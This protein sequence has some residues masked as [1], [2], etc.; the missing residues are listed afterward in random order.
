[1]ILAARINFQAMFKTFFKQLPKDRDGKVTVGGFEE[2]LKERNYQ[3]FSSG[4]LTELGKERNET[5]EFTDALELYYA[6]RTR[7]PVCDG[8]QAFLKD[9]FF[10]CVECYD[11]GD[12][13]RYYCVTC[14]KDKHACP[15]GHS[16]FL[17]N[18]ALLQF[19][20]NY[21]KQEAKKDKSGNRYRLQPNASKAKIL[22]H[23][24]FNSVEDFY[25]KELEDQR[26]ETVRLNAGGN[27]NFDGNCS[28]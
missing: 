23:D 16:I 3:G 18:Y 6:V 13:P 15:A 22:C 26:S 20:S 4:L 21:M 5:L 27:I 9:L 17:D 14:R 25:S 24:V 8:C 28:F 19:R 11:L 2:F 7:R 12:R 1:M 10:C